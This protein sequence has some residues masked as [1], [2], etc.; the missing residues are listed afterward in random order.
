MNNTKTI[1][2]RFITE[3][4]EITVDEDVVFSLL[5]LVSFASGNAV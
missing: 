3:V 5:H 4:R 2:T 1:V